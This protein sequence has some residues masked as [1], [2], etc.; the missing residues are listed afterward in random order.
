MTIHVDTQGVDALLGG[1]DADARV[2]DELVAELGQLP[3]VPYTAR[4]LEFDEQPWLQLPTM[5]ELAVLWGASPVSMLISDIASRME[6]DALLLAE[7]RFKAD[8]ELA[9][10]KEREAQ[11]ADHGTRLDQH[12]AG[13]AAQA[14]RG[15]GAVP[16]EPENGDSVGEGGETPSDTNPRRPQK[17]QGRRRQRKA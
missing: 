14:G 11:D 1:Y 3:P 13:S 16:G 4:E 10:I 5:R 7:E 17:I 2:W 15:G 9:W 12:E 8:I 6:L